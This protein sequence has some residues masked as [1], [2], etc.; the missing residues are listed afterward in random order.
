MDEPGPEKSCSCIR[1][2]LEIINLKNFMRDYFLTFTLTNLLFQ[3]PEYF[4]KL[5]L[6]ELEIS[7]RQILKTNNVSCFSFHVL[8]HSFCDFRSL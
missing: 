1:D 8:C 6:H 4:K 7:V 3:F 2:V 5:D